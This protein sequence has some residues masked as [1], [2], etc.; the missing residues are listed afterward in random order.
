MKKLDTLSSIE[1]RLLLQDIFHELKYEKQLSGVK[2]LFRCWKLCTHERE[3]SMYSSKEAIVLHP[4]GFFR[5]TALWME[6]ILNR[7]YFSTINSFVYFGAAI[8]LVLIGIRRFSDT[9][10]DTMV[11]AGLAFEALMLLVMFVVML[12]TPREDLVPS[13]NNDGAVGIAED[14]LMEIGEIGRDF[15]AAVAQLEELTGSIKEFT[16]KQEQLLGEVEKASSI[17]M[18]AVSPNPEMLDAMKQTG[19]ALR[20]FTNTVKE[21]NRAACEIKKEEIELSV[22]KEIERLIVDKVAKG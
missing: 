16:N 13:Q 12:F 22:R 2:T 17:A 3:M 11:I 9:I 21:L 5:G 1:G 14:L 10:T 8:L 15:A 18:Q 19:D 6:E 7:F 4:L 20:E